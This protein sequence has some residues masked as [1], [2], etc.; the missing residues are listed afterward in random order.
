[1]HIQKTHTQSNQTIQIYELTQLEMAF[2]IEAVELHIIFHNFQYCIY[3]VDLPTTKNKKSI[4]LEELL[5]A[6][7][8]HS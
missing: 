4:K 8:P 5:L 7:Y 2:K 6:L 1:M 3:F